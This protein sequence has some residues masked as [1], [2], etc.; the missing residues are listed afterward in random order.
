METDQAKLWFTKHAPTRAAQDAAADALPEIGLGRRPVATAHHEAAHAV[1]GRLL[2]ADVQRIYLTPTGGQCDSLT[3]GGWMDRD[4]AISLLAGPIAS[5]RI[6]KKYK[7]LI[8]VE[9][10][11]CRLAQL[12]FPQ[13]EDYERAEKEARSM[14]HENWLEIVQV[15]RRLLAA[16]E[17]IL[18]GAAIW[19]D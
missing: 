16:P 11:D 17:P 6:L 15:A 3:Y 10:Q 4:D 9:S 2:G 19:E 1:I 13:W 5:F 12:I 8:F 7:T 18:R 14:V